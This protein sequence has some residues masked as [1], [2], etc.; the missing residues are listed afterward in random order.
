MAT[1]LASSTSR[2]AEPTGSGLP[3]RGLGPD[4]ACAEVDLLCASDHDY[5]DGTVFN[6]ISSEPFALAKH[7][8]VR[9][10]SANMGDNRIFPSLQRAEQA[11]TRMLGDLLGRPECAGVATSGATEA[12]LLAVLSAVR[13]WAAGVPSRGRAR[14]VLP[15]SAHFSFDKILGLLPIE[16]VRVPLNGRYRADTEAALEAT[17]PGTAL[18]VLTAGTS[19]TGA[20]D[21]IG[22]I[23][24]RAAELDVP[25]HVDAATGGFLVPFAR[26][27][28]MELAD[29][30]FGVP[31]VTSI[32]V[33]PHKYGGAPIPSG[34]L[35][36]RSEEDLRR[37][38]IRSHYQGTH[39]HVSLLGTRPGAAVLATYALLRGLGRDGY[40]EVVNELFLRRQLL[41]QGLTELGMP[42]AFPP[43]LLVV[44]C[45]P[46]DPA[47]VVA[48]LE[49]R[50]LI[51]SVARRFGFL[52]LV[53]HWH[54]TRA[55]LHDL[56]AQLA[57]IGAGR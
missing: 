32:A 28:G 7:V 41:L 22:P 54:Q 38:R 50:G 25:V 16:P 29:C 45:R 52:R 34:H 36:M 43:D 13:R 37:L 14:V 47:R 42:M 31:G 15:E 20:V 39:D 57:E 21:D 11:I 17:T 9:H 55:M 24:C 49:H 33:D 12:N 10:L 1:L 40:R 35:L 4:V 27:L 19:E 6:S 51:A 18:V 8:Y 5:T 44:G 23:A 30:G 26:E 53:V 56:L 48:E 3:E 46:D 2:N